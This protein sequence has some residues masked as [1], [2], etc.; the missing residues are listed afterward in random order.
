MPSHGWTKAGLQIDDQRRLVGNR[1]AACRGCTRTA[2][3]AAGASLEAQAR[4]A[5]NRAGSSSRSGDRRGV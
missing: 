5:C 2:E 3:D 1:E 4:D